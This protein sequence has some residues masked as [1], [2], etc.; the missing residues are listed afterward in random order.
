[1]TDKPIM[2]ADEVEEIRQDMGAAAWIGQREIGAI[3]GWVAGWFAEYVATL[4]AVRSG[5]GNEVA[6][7]DRW[8]RYIGRIPLEIDG[9]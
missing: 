9:S 6:L 4:R 5:D 2:S 3:N 1:M 7:Y 8:G